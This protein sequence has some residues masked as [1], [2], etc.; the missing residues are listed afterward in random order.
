MAKNKNNQTIWKMRVQRKSSTLFQ[1]IGSSIEIDKNLYKQDIEGSIAH[2]EMLF[3]QKIISFKIKNKI[4]YGLNKVRKLNQIKS[5]ENHIEACLEI[6]L[7]LIVHSTCLAPAETPAKELA[8][9]KPRSLW[10]CTEK[11]A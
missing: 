2:V 4:F 3:R 5:F 1:K 6:N 7:P 9:A 8:T 11:I 10:Q